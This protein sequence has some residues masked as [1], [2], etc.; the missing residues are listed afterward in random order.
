[1]QV[2]PECTHS[3]PYRSFKQIATNLENNSKMSL[4]L[5]QTERIDLIEVLHKSY[6]F[7]KYFTGFMQASM[8]KIQGI[9]KDF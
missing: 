1:M 8:S 9:F 3:D 7:V 6:Q 4:G 5:F 2:P